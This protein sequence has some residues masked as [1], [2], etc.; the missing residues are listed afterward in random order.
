MII[1]SW[2]HFSQ[3]WGGRSDVFYFCFIQIKNDEEVTSSVFSPP[4]IPTNWAHGELS[5]FQRMSV[6]K[7]GYLSLLHMTLEIWKI[8]YFLLIKLAGFEVMHWCPGTY[9]VV[10]FALAY[11][12]NVPWLILP[13]SQLFPIIC[14]CLY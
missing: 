6:V 1:V 2:T 11:I 10:L 5:S 8:I 14:Y 3:N 4:R 7:H 12:S 9:R 13:C